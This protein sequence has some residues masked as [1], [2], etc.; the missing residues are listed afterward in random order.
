MEIRETSDAGTPIVASQPDSTHA[1]IYHAI[2]DKILAELARGK[3]EAPKFIM[4]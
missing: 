3:R 2:A 1:K 4:E